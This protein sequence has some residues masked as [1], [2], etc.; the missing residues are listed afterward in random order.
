MPARRDDNLIT[1]LDRFTHRVVANG[2]VQPSWF[3]RM[4]S[5]K[6]AQGAAFGRLE[7]IA[8]TIPDGIM[9]HL[10][11]GR[12]EIVHDRRFIDADDNIRTEQFVYLVDRVVVASTERDEQ[13]F[14]VGDI[15]NE[16]IVLGPQTVGIGGAACRTTFRAFS[17]KHQ[18]THALNEDFRDGRQNET[19]A[20]AQQLANAIVRRAQQAKVERVTDPLTQG[21]DTQIH[22]YLEDVWAYTARRYVDSDVSESGSVFYGGNTAGEYIGNLLVAELARAP[23][24]RR[25]LRSPF[26]VDASA[27]G[28]PVSYTPRWERLSQAL[29]VACEIGTGP[30]ALDRVPIILDYEIDTEDRVLVFKVR[31]GRDRRSGTDRVHLSDPFVGNDVDV[32][33]GDLVK[34]SAWLPGQ[35]TSF[36][37]SDEICMQRDVIVE[38]GE[39]TTVRADTGV[40]RP[41]AREWIERTVDL[42]QQARAGAA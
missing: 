20:G 31:Q 4:F 30:E 18:A 6:R 42:M 37:Q 16:A 39:Q 17:S 8:N 26:S 21:E 3:S 24:E 11:S 1:I 29:R 34:H 14:H 27:V 15:A 38:P 36:S 40:E 41:D 25:R 10:I 35:T 12:A 19:E 22:I 33:P 2:I 9:Q 7:L 23:I 28:L 5:S 32:R 13:T